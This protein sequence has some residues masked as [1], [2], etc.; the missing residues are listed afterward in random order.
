MKPEDPKRKQDAEHRHE[1]ESC[2]VHGPD[3]QERRDFIRRSGEI[4]FAMTVL[5]AFGGAPAGQKST[6]PLTQA[7]KLCSLQG[8][9]QSATGGTSADEAC[10]GTKTQQQVADASTDQGCTQGDNPCSPPPNHVPDASCSQTSADEGCHI[11]SAPG[12]SSNDEDQHCGANGDP[13]NGC[14]DCDDNHDTDNH[15]GQP[16]GGGGGNDRDELCGH[17][18]YW[19][20]G[21]DADDRCGK[22]VAGG[23]TEV[24]EGCGQHDTIYHDW[25]DPDDN[26][27]G[28]LPGGGTDVDSNCT[29]VQGGDQT[30]GEDPPGYASSPDESCSL[31]SQDEAC[32]QGGSE[33]YN[34]AYDR[35]ASCGGTGPGVTE[36]QDQSCGSSAGN[37]DDPD[38]NCGKAL[39][40]GATDPDEDCGADLAG[41]TDPDQNCG[42]AAGGSTDVDESC[43]SGMFG[44][45]DENCGNPLPGGG[46]DADDNCGGLFGSND[47]TCSKTQTAGQEYVAVDEDAACAR[48]E[49][50]GGLQYTELDA[51]LEDDPQVP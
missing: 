10:S 13:D 21:G 46:T 6:Q 12:G 11:K 9:T 16:L 37:F 30:C 47:A 42:K 14:G 27:G 3:S 45:T 38:Q 7:D 41:G 31:T 51:V 33:G 49:T 48:T 2:P 44:S 19:P 4:V 28:T 17:P 29:D 32:G 26:C 22:P 15:C 35:D 8:E 34:P 18:H 20:F 24:D 39:P 43:G 36:S 40:G 1:D 23:G 5:G 50:G 25:A